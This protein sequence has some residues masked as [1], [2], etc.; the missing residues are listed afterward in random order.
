M[1]DYLDEI[2]TYVSECNFQ[3]IPPVVIKRAKEAIADS[4]AVIAKGAQEEEVK[5]LTARTW[6]PGAPEVATLIGAGIRTEPLNAGL[7]N[8]TAGTF[9]ELDEGNRFA[10]GHPAIHVI[11]AAL[12][13]AEEKNVSGKEFLTAFVLGYE[14]GA[15]IGGACRLRISMQSHGTWGTVGAAAAVGKLKGYKK[16]G[17]KQ[18]INVSSALSLATSN[19]AALEG[20]TVR[21]VYAGVSGYMGILADHLVQSGFTGEGDGLNTV[22]GSVVSDTF[23]PELMTKEFGQRFEIMRNYFKRHA[24]CRYIHSTL[25]SL[26]SIIAKRPGR[27]IFPNEVAKVEVMSYSL[28]VR[29][30]D[31][32]P[33]STLAGKFSIPFAVS[34]FIV[35]GS[36][37]VDSF[38]PQAVHDPVVRDLAQ[39]VTVVE[40]PKFT[41]MMP[42]HRPSRVRITITDGTV[43]EAQILNSKG[44]VEDP[45]TSE[46]IR[47][48]YFDLA[49]G[50]WD[51]DVAEAIYA[52]VMTL[53]ELANVSQMTN[54][55]SPA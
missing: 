23:L 43:L 25:D 28:A 10:R 39:R 18:I 11:P 50:V 48:K 38:T 12:A 13:V 5:A 8:G 45:Y 17:M 40:D 14:I 31:Q 4:L 35:H 9:L 22:F 30:C 37:G 36:A 20:G 47:A 49:E 27:R 44:D 26:G 6:V 53:D 7:I 3:D 51:H 41:E 34:S 55:M 42:D 24:C 54:R 52:D 2:A 46:D 19:R 29:L 33:Q 15:R 32:N 16:Q 1:P 21:N